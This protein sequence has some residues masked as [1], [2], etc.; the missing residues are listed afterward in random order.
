MRHKSEVLCGCGVF[1]LIGL[2]RAFLV[3]GWSFSIDEKIIF[4]SFIRHP[5]PRL[6]V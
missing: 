4:Y 6:V 5:T 3:Q 1:S 2:L